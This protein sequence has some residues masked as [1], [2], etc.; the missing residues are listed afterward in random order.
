[1]RKQHVQERCLVE[2]PGM[3]GGPTMTTVDLALALGLS[4]A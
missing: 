4:E 2:A 3:P 1:L